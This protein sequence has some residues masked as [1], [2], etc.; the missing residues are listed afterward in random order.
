LVVR[1]NIKLAP[2]IHGGGQENGLRSG[3]ENTAGIVSLAHAAEHLH[4]NLSASCKKVK[5]LRD[6]LAELTDEIP[7]A[8][9]NKMCQIDNGRGNPMRS[10]GVSPYILSMSFPGVKGEVL[11]HML[12]EKGIHASTGAACKSRKKDKSTLAL[13][14]FPKEITES[15]VRFSFS[16]FNTPDEIERTKESIIACV[17]QLRK[18]RGYK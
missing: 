1:G 2:L 17:N 4:G 13:M 3:T 14:S 5:K 11:V 8:A 12:S 18:I 10:T 6:S 15:A 9:V 7:G 16:H